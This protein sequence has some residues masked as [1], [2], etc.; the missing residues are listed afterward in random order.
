MLQQLNLCAHF[1]VCLYSLQYL[2][3]SQNLSMQTDTETQPLELKP[4]PRHPRLHP[5]V[6]AVLLLV[7]LI[8]VG[9]LLV[10]ARSLLYPIG[11]AIMLAYLL[12]P[13]TSWLEKKMGLHRI[14]AN[15]LGIAGL[16]VASYLFL[17]LMYAQMSFFVEDMPAMQAQ[18]MANLNE[19]LL[20]LQ[21]RYGINAA[22]VK[23]SINEAIESADSKAITQALGATM[24]TAV[25]V[26][27]LPVYTFFLLYY[28]NKFRQFILK[29]VSY[30][31]HDRT[32]KIL[33]DIQY[34]TKRY[35]SGI[36]IVVAILSVLNS[37][38]MVVI[39]LEHAILLGVL[40]ALMNFIPYFGTLIG[41]AIP[42]LVCT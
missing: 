13:L 24:G 36:V 23:Q 42:L 35:I 37:I 21:N 2:L 16:L 19:F 30:R 12:Y 32:E 6:T 34:V 25:A 39:G 22:E 38:G 28:R 29:V 1:T 8:I 3:P 31:H 15:I 5:L 10:I 20:L 18:A 4:V 41:A 17:K 40:S 26:G 7:L 33:Y 11:L 27:I 14:L 9:W